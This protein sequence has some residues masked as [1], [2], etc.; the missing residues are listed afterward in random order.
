MRETA[1]PQDS[2]R[3]YLKSIGRVP[4]LTREQEITFGKRVQ[5]YMQLDEIRQGLADNRRQV[6]PEEI[7]DDSPSPYGRRE[8]QRHCTF[9]QTCL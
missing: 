5:R 2:V 4:L 1:P 3:I 9:D 8:S 7:E 6:T